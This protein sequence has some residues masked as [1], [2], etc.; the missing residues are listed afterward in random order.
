MNYLPTSIISGLLFG[1]IDGL[2]NANPL[3]QKLFQVYKP[4]A[5]T[6]I[7]MPAGFVIDLFYG[8]IMAWVFLMLNKSLPGSTNVLKGLSFGLIMW[9][10]RVVMSVATTWMMFKVPPQAL[11]YILLTGLVEMLLIGLFYGVT[12]K[13]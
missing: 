2:I 4:I 12:L 9:F 10:F 11:V 6:S 13:V 7:N 1:F 3:A 8:F 5:K